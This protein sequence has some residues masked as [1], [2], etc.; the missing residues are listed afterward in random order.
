ML[1]VLAAL[2]AFR[3]YPLR[4]SRIVQMDPIVLLSI[5]RHVPKKEQARYLWNIRCIKEWRHKDK[6]RTWR[7]E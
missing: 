4:R 3:V 2:R 7:K 5:H 1:Q 6:Q